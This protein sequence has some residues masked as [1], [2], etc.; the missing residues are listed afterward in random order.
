MQEALTPAQVPVTLS[1]NGLKVDK[2]NPPGGPGVGQWG[3]VLSIPR[4]TACLCLLGS[5]VSLKIVIY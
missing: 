1:W 3:A 2:T 5:Q 4:H